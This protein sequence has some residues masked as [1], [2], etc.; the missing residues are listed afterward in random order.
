MPSRADDGARAHV[1]RVETD[2]LLNPFHKHTMILFQDGHS[3]CSLSVS[4]SH[5]LAYRAINERLIHPHMGCL[6]PS[7]CLAVLQRCGHL[8]RYTAVSPRKINKHLNLLRGEQ[9][10]YSPL[11]L[12][13][14]KT[15]YCENVGKRWLFLSLSCSKLHHQSQHRKHTSELTWMMNDAKLAF[16]SRA[17]ERLNNFISWN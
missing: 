9:T 14:P 16:S 1:N 11:T 10:V 2:C 12:P 7:L 13:N 15:S 17:S 8:L 4:P 6:R 3:N 5:V